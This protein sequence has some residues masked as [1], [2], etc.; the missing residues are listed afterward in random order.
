MLNW[1]TKCILQ[2][3]VENVGTTI[4]GM[5]KT[6]KYPQAWKPSLY[7]FLSLALNVTTHE[8]HF[9]WYTDSKVGPAFSQVLLIFWEIDYLQSVVTTFEI[10]VIGE[11]QT[12]ETYLP[13]LHFVFNCLDWLSAVTTG[14]SYC[15]QSLE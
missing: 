1:L 8:G 11:Y 4:R 3:V 12:V 7:M 6:I 14:V 2:G 13:N 5:Y 15:R 9:Y 10:S